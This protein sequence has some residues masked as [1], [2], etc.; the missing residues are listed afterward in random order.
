M[1]TRR[2]GEQS[3]RRQLCI[4]LLFILWMAAIIWRLAYLQVTRHADYRVR[5][6]AQRQETITV[7]PLRGAI[8]DRRGLELAISVDTDSLFAYA[9]QVKDPEK[10]ARVLSP[11]VGENKDALLKKLTGE[12]N[13]VWLKRKLDFNTAQSVTREIER[14]KLE[15]VHLIKEAQRSYPNGSLAAHLLGQVDIDEQGIAGLEKTHDQY[16]RGQPGQVLLET[17]ARRRPYDRHD[18]PATSGS[19]VVTTL[20]L[21]L[22]HKVEQFLAEALEATRARGATAVVLNPKTGEILALANA[23]TFDPNLRPKRNSDANDGRMRR[24]RAVTDIYEPGSVFK[25]VTYSA[26]IE[27]GLARPDEKID[28]FNGQIVLAGR[29][30]RDTHAYGL[31]TVAEALAKS[32]NGGAIRLALR[33]GN[34]RLSDYIARFGFGRK[35]GV[36]IPGEENGIVQDVSKWRQN[37]IGYIAIGHEVG[38]TALQAVAAMSAIAN[39]G[40]WVQP[41]L[42]K[43]VI[44]KDGRVIYEARPETRRVVSEQTAVTVASMLEGVVSR[45]T[46][47]RAVKFAGYDGAGK[48]GTA[49]KIDSVTRRYSQTK[50][51]ASF[52]GFVPATNPRFAI[53]VTLD[54][55]VGLHQGGQVAAPVFNRIAEAALSDYVVPPNIAAFRERLARL[56]EHA[57]EQAAKDEQARQ[58]DDSPAASN[59][60]GS[61]TSSSLVVATLEIEPGTMPDL[62]GRGVRAVVRACAN[63]DLKLKVN[64]SGVAVH[65]MPAPGARI[66]PGEI[67]QVEFQ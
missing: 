61:V 11:L 1:R 39:R 30:I 26:A 32:S 67:C 12:A 31:L 6:E 36:D 45:G 42:V 53:I 15:G 54:E 56:E 58:R 17:D 8:V 16:L 5:A 22:Q 10:V 33:V 27:E 59:E 41:H 23:P 4:A 2:R 40:L 51:A 14:H 47:R 21:T 7:S 57:R 49:Q 34:E 48:T 13:F 9:R 44:G 25:T 3:G 35:T 28:C 52:A 60:D 50:F 18:R 20:D 62:R 63:L 19:Q 46:A 37:S 29:A 38:V 66:K 55:P 64:G 65:Q 24:N 43:Q